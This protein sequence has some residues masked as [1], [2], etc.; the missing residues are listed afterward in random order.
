MTD[1]LPADAIPQLVPRRP[2]HAGKESLGGHLVVIEGPDGSGRSTQI[3]LLKEWLESAGFA[4][5]TI[6]LRRSNLLARNIDNVLAKNLVGRLTL[7]LM[8][9]TDFFDQ[10]ENIMIPAL[11]SGYIVLADRYIY[12]LIARAAVRGINPEYLDR[13]YEMAL[14]P[15]MTFWLNL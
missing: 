2:F 3:E 5:Q 1:D 9:A 8:Y 12:T 7:A 15:E 11:R 14:K 6:G 4:V 10:L 13:I